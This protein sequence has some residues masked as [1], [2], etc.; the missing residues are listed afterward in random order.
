M[1]REWTIDIE[2]V[3]EAENIDVRDCKDFLCGSG[4][5]AHLISYEMKGG[6]RE[7][8]NSSS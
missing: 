5:L 4:A 6:K 2:D 3:L 8:F 7:Y 1:A